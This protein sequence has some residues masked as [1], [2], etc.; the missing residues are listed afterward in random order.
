MLASEK[1]DERGKEGEVAKCLFVV[2]GAAERTTANSDGRHWRQAVP[3][4][5][6]KSPSTAFLCLL[7]DTICPVL[8]CAQ[9]TA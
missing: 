1:A 2:P 8:T 7:R 3:G 5:A 4:P 9:W 6:Q